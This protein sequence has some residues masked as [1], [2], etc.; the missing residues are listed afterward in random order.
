VCWST[1]E[2]Y[3]FAFLGLK[4]GTT[5]AISTLGTRR[6]KIE[7]ELFL[8]GYEEMLSRVEPDV[9]YCYGRPFPAMEGHIIHIDYAETIRRSA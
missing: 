4:K 3:Q 9:I 5:V 2:S 1:Y 8:K 6:G 7:Q